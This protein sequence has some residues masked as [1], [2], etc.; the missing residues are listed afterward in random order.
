[1]VYRYI[2][3][4][5]PLFYTFSILGIV[6]PGS[7][8]VLLPIPRKIT[9]IFF[10]FFSETDGDQKKRKQSEDV[11]KH[12]QQSDSMV[13]SDIFCWPDF[14][15][16]ILLF[17]FWII[18]LTKFCFGEMMPLLYFFCWINISDLFFLIFGSLNF[19]RF[20]SYAQIF[21]DVPPPPLVS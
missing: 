21:R 10:N 18:L 8:H 2:L 5:P 12:W 9:T 1:M 11:R 20:M 7:I 19:V 3:Y 15:G 16:I 6:L 14:C 4:F 17:V 13:F